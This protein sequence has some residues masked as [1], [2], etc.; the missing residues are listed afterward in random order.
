ME[1][2]YEEAWQIIKN[3]DSI[4]IAAHIN[5]DGDAVGSVMAMYYTLKKMGKKVCYHLEG[6]SQTM[7]YLLD[8]ENTE[9]DVENL[10]AVDIGT[11]KMLNDCVRDRFDSCILNI[12]HHA[13]NNMFAENTLI[14]ADCA[15]ACEVIFNL[16][17]KMNIAIDDR[18]ANCLYLGITTDTGCFRYPNTTADTMLTASK[19]LRF[20]VD[21]GA[22][23][24]QQFETKTRGMIEFERMAMNTLRT[25][26]NDR[27][28]VISL[29]EDMFAKAG[30][31]ECD[32][33]AVTSM[34]KMLEGVLAGVVIKQRGHDFWKISIRSNPPA[35]ASDM[36]EE[37][38]GG[39]HKA[40]AGAEVYGTLE[41]ATEKVL[42]A[43]RKHI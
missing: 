29:T 42:S 20:K 37:L 22:I 1:I 6:V 40:A 7:E 28:A 33:H 32:I 10:F 3:T 5:P 4:M 34:P 9:F 35:C 11:M 24:K 25:Y 27:I 16:F 41:E 12:D 2:N 38:G 15:A 18:V 21:N 17:E 8:P 14:K 13:T 31:R 43:I 30:V 26:D 36:C 39:G 23:N 19:L